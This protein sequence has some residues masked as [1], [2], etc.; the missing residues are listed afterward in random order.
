M[1]RFIEH[2]QV[3]TAHLQYHC[4]AAH[5]KYSNNTLS[6]HRLTSNSFS[7]A[8]FPWIALTANWT[9]LHNSLTTCSVLVL[10]LS[11][12]LYCTTL[13][14]NRS[15]LYRLRMDHRKTQVAWLLSRQSIGALSAGYQRAIT[16]AHWDTVSI[17]DDVTAFHN[18]STHAN[19]FTEPLPR[20]GLHNPI[21][22][23]LFAFMEPLPG[24]ALIK[25]VTILK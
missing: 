12:A 17:V 13:S 6:L 19:V 1:N 20:N 16:F 3:I 10:V 14:Y 24:N 7:A 5:I 4:T 8:N 2:S 21:V 18:I 25:S 9:N 23:L 11:T 22:L 15:S